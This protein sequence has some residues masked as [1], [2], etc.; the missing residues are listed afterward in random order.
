MMRILLTCRTMRMGLVIRMF[1]LLSLMLTL[2][3]RAL[4]PVVLIKLVRVK[5]T[6]A[7]RRVI[8]TCVLMVDGRL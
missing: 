8:V 5:A 1:T 7:G 2:V 6:R 4:I 3:N